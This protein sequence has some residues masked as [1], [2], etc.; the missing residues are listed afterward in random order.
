MQF[1][2]EKVYISTNQHGILS[3]IVYAKNYNNRPKNML[4]F[5]KMWLPEMRTGIYVI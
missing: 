4:K 1:L 3:K 2:I 5:Y